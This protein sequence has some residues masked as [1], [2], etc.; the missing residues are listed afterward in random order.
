[1]SD[2]KG[3]QSQFFL[4]EGDVLEAAEAPPEAPQKNEKLRQGIIFFSI[5]MIFTLVFLVPTEGI[6]SP[7]REFS[8]HLF[9]TL[10]FLAFFAE[11]TSSCVGEGYGLFVSPALIIRGFSPFVIL[12]AVLVSEFAN[13]IFTTIAHQRLGNINLRDRFY[14]KMALVFSA[15]G[16]VGATS[17]A[18]LATW[19]VDNLGEFVLKVFIACVFIVTG[20]L[21]V[22][23]SKLHWKFAWS[24]VVGLGLFGSFNK[25]MAGGGFGPVTTGGQLIMNIMPRRAVAVSKFAKGLTCL[26]GFLTYIFLKDNCLSMDVTLSMGI[27]ASLAAPLAAWTVGGLDHE[28]LKIII[29]AITLLLGVMIIVFLFL[30]EAGG[31]H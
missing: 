7:D 27:G 20:V 31:A 6:R 16:V 4:S 26:S 14:L 2:A 24:K 10:F 3:T 9:I 18:F 8:W 13:A 23:S 17:A 5:V 30:G 29:A 11:Y 21:I 15:A 19:V 25:S 28:K 12:P 1:M 22:L